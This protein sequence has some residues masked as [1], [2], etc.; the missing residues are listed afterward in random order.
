[1]VI[2]NRPENIFM[3]QAYIYFI[4]RAAEIFQ[5]KFSVHHQNNSTLSLCFWGHYPICHPLEQKK[6]VLWY[7]CHRVFSTAYL[8]I[9]SDKETKSEKCIPSQ[10]RKF[11]GKLNSLTIHFHIIQFSTEEFHGIYNNNKLGLIRMTSN[12]KYN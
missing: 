11:I 9:Y 2:I 12:Q 10:R 8:I 6:K 4:F 7:S 5:V 3:D 1:M